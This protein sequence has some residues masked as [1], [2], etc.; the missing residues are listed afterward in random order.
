MHREAVAR[1]KSFH[2][3]TFKVTCDHA[4]PLDALRDGLRKAATSHDSS[5]ETMRDFLVRHVQSVVILKDE[6]TKLSGCGLRSRLP[7]GASL[8]DMMARYRKAGITFE[9]EDEAKLNRVTP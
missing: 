8:H 2:G 1:G 7:V 9:P 3:K 5:C 6:N 4:V